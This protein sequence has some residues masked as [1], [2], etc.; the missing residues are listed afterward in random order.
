LEVKAVFFDFD[1]ILTFDHAAEEST[2]NAISQIFS[3]PEE[4]VS[5]AYGK[6]GNH[7]LYAGSK[8]IGQF[9]KEFYTNLGLP[10]PFVIFQEARQDIYGLTPMDPEMIDL[11]KQIQR[12]GLVTGII[13]NN[14]SERVEYLLEKYNLLD[15]FNPVVI[16]GDS[17]KTKSDHT[18]FFDAF[19]DTKAAVFIDNQQKNCDSAEKAGMHA[20]YFDDKI[21]DYVKLKKELALFGISI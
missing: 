4:K 20:I 6:S 11:V 15:L 7:E 3:I 2:C 10:F 1:G 13:T 5:E 19:P 21:R 14:N 17:M 18:L 8:S 12:K 9:W 16:S